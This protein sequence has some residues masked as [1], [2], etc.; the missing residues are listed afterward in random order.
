MRLGRPV[1]R[2]IGG[3]FHCSSSDCV[4]VELKL[5]RV[6]HYDRS[7][8]L[9]WIGSDRCDGNNLDYGIGVREALLH[10]RTGVWRTTEGD[11]W[12]DLSCWRC[13]TNNGFHLYISSYVPFLHQAKDT[14]CLLSRVDTSQLDLQG[15]RL[16]SICE[17]C[18]VGE[19]VQL[20]FGLWTSTWPW[21]N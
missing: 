3:S 17:T 13:S 4:H 2:C 6:G 9:F 18:I 12:S 16:V 10:L 5:V 19:Y 1:I 7:N 20:G 8:A 11:R 21:V 14:A 15:R